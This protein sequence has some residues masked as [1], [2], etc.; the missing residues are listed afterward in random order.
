MAVLKA[1]E[2]EMQLPHRELKSEKKPMCR[3]RD[4]VQWHRET[5]IIQTLTAEASQG[6]NTQPQQTWDAG[7]FKLYN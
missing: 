2:K 5:S 6:L 7:L 4:R 3:T 1:R